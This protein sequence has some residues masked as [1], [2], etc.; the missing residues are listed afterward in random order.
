MTEQQQVPLSQEANDIFD[1]A[2]DLWNNTDQSKRDAKWHRDVA[3]LFALGIKKAN[4]PV[5]WAHSYL[6]WFLYWLVP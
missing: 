6:S 4:R 5:S 2:I 1:K 3:S